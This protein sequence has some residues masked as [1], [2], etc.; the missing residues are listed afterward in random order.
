MAKEEKAKRSSN[1]VELLS[2]YIARIEKA[3]KK[4]EQKHVILSSDLPILWPLY[5][6]RMFYITTLAAG[7]RVKTHQHAENVFRY[8]IE[9]A[10]DVTVKEKTYT[11]KAGMW[12]AIRANT[13]YSLTTRSN[14]TSAKLFSAYQYQ[15]KL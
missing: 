10:I 13:S 6:H 2:A 3:L 14:P 7:T 4:V 5:E 12:I 9:G 1:E 15:C 8:V 11:V